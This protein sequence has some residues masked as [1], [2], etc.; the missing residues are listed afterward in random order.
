MSSQPFNLDNYRR[1]I[2]AA[3]IS[4]DMKARL[5]KA[6]GDSSM[7]TQVMAVLEKHGSTSTKKTMV[8]QQVG[9]GYIARGKVYS[10]PAL[11]DGFPGGRKRKG[12][13][14]RKGKHSEVRHIVRDGKPVQ[15]AANGAG[16]GGAAIDP[17]TFEVTS[18]GF[19]SNPPAGSG[20]IADP[21]A[22][23]YNLLARL[24]QQVN[25]M[26]HVP[27]RRQLPA[28][29]KR[30]PEK[31]KLMRYYFAYGS[32]LSPSQ[33]QHR[34][35]GA[36]AVY[37][38]TLKGYK[39]VFR[40][41]ADIE[42]TGNEADTVPGVIYKIS[43]NHESDLDRFEGVSSGSYRKETFRFRDKHRHWHN[44]LFYKKNGDMICSPSSAYLSR[45]KRGYEHYA[46]ATAKLQEAVKHAEDY[47]PPPRAEIDFSEG[48][49]DGALDLFGEESELPQD[50]EY[51]DEE[52]SNGQHEQ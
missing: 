37:K 15:L 19:S 47:I 12:K 1:A 22:D 8:V 2:E 49:A 6:A 45:I 23:E 29:A 38:H 4:A 36:E 3:P 5:L 46:L 33:M 52:E 32:N 11:E 16:Y 35:P 20:F 24:R 42:Y 27:G 25:K 13:K 17:A 51:G 40:L 31:D 26:G 7:A 10:A 14:G 28:P 44:V 9:S 30:D 50:G 39:L 34:C 21:E 43:A 41:Y 18:R 48:D